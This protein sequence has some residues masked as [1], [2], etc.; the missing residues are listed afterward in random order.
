M[1]LLFWVTAL[2]KEVYLSME[3]TFSRIH[4]S[5]TKVGGEEF[6]QDSWGLAENI[7]I[8]G[9]K[10]IFVSTE[11]GDIYERFMESEF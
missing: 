2:S 10:I 9:C 7:Y 5:A 1:L 8:Q 4:S 3:N 11:K 6:P